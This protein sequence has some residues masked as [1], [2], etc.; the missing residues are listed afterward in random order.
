MAASRRTPDPL[1]IA[2]ARI[3]G[4]AQR[5]AAGR[6]SSDAALVEVGAA[7]GAL[8][9]VQWGE[10]LAD[11]ASAFVDRSDSVAGRV[12]DVLQRAGVDLDR[13]AALRAARP[14]DGFLRK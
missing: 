6:V 8:P 10:A 12:L 5:C 14:G 3:S 9:D 4:I 2:A 13:A 7:L 11:A 1:K